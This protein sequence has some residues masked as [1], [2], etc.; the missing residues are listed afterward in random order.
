MIG[1][2][3]KSAAIVREF[4]DYIIEGSEVHVMLKNPTDA[5]AG[6]IKALNEELEDIDVALVVKDCLDMEDLL[7]VRP[8]EYDNIIVLA[9]TSS[10]DGATDAARVDSENIV[11]MLLLRRIFSQYPAESQNTKLITEILDSQNDELVAKA[12]V[13]DV[14]ISNRLVSMIMA[15]I[16]ES[17]DIEKVYDDIFQEDGSE[18]YLKPAHLYFNALPVEVTFADLM[19]LAQRRGEICIGVK[20]KSLENSKE[21][22]NGIQLIPEKNTR[23]ELHA[24]DSLV[25]LSED[26]L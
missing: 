8:F 11:A 13:K 5:Q 14:I 9:G 22:N 21:D 2:T 25:V 3:F 16:S 4:A 6:E 7:S 26:E 15:Q 24:E 1:W 19:G 18:I 23:F 12:G 20:N 17:R 10:D